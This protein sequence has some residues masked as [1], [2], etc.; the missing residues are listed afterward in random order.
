M[1]CCL[2]GW[3]GTVERLFWPPLHFIQLPMGMPKCYR[4]GEGKNKTFLALGI[5]F[6][7]HP[8]SPSARNWSMAPKIDGRYML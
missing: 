8:Q 7:W 5:R 2:A 1:L 4:L 3:F 6:P